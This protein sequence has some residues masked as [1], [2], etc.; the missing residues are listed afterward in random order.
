VNARGFSIRIQ[1]AAAFAFVAFFS[2]LVLGVAMYQRVSHLVRSDVRER[3]RTIAGLAA[4]HVDGDAH[5]SL[6]GRADEATPTY[7]RI[8]A[9]L[10][11]IR[12]RAPGIRYVYTIRLDARGQIV[13]AVDAE[14]DPKLVSHVGDVYKE[15]TPLMRRA[16]DAPHEVRV[17][18]SFDRDKWGLW[19]SGYAPIFDSSGRLEAL[20]G[21]DMSAKKVLSH[22]RDYL[23]TVVIVCGISG[24]IFLFLGVW[25]A[26]RISQPLALLE[27][28]MSRI[29][30]LNLDGSL[31]IR[32]RIKEVMRMRDALES[33]RSG[34]RS[35]KKYVPADLVTELIELHQEAVLGGQ[36]RELSILF[37]D[38]ADFTTL[39]E[40]LTP[41]ELVD[42]LGRYLEKMSQVILAHRGTID[43]FIGDAVM[44]FWGAP[45]PLPDHAER[46]CRAALEAS[47]LELPV[48]DA[49]GR[50]VGVFRT[51]FGIATGEV[52]VGNLGHE[53]R[54]SYTVIGDRVNV[55]SRA[56]GL[57]KLYG[58]SVLITEHTRDL[59]SGIFVTRPV[60]LV[61]VKGKA[62]GLLMHELLGERS[63]CDTAT[64]ELAG[65]CERAFAHYQARAWAEA[66]AAYDAALALRPDDAAVT[67]LRARCERYRTEPPGPD[68]TGVVTLREK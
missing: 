38:I 34:L 64:L 9:A 61:A 46:A 52:I 60:D 24:A 23:L 13:F 15:A 49:A 11:Q 17:E 41:E 65:H 25:L 43:K 54:L 48:T 3:I 68:W 12:S 42:N 30:G 57:N 22:E 33:M 45:H 2:A 39:G 37:S 29:Q 7:R 32:S 31:V 8:K 4:L 50:P 35:F 16:F 27:Q 56:E 26:S 59:V 14:E 62:Q 21:V 58:T 1:L 18:K 40:R 20:V 44:A 53:A 19:L 5:R 66:I 36:R 28:E 47:R 55:A 10:K 63:A 67:M 51:R 6:R